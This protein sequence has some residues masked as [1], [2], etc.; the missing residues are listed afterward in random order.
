[1]ALILTSTSQRRI[2]ISGTDLEISSVYLRIEFNS[3]MDGKTIDLNAAAYANKNMYLS[4]MPVSVDIVSPKVSMNIDPV[5]QTQGIDTAHQLLKSFYE[6][7]G[8]TV[9]IDMN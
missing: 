1:M 4:G 6:E 8:Y 7:N 5:S 3:R 9:A 2:N